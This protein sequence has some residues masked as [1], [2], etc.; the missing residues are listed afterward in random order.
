MSN[1]VPYIEKDLD[2][3]NPFQQTLGALAG[4]LKLHGNFTRHIKENNIETYNK[5]MNSSKRKNFLSAKGSSPALVISP[6]DIDVT[7]ML[8]FTN[9][10]GRIVMGFEFTLLDS[11]QKV[12]DILEL[13][14]QMFLAMNKFPRL[15]LSFVQDVTWQVG[16]IGQAVDIGFLDFETEGWASFLP[17]I[18]S[19]SIS[20]EDLNINTK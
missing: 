17:V 4:S 13:T 14:W 20:Q 5:K 15:A 9:C 16:S 2:I 1:V 18:V 11:S 6:S 3:V 10:A 7:Q 12:D 8:G 19:Y